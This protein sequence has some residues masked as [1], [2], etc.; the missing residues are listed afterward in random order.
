[1]GGKA[2]TSDDVEKL[3]EYC[4]KGLTTDQIAEKLGRTWSAVSGQVFNM[5]KAGYNLAIVKNTD[6]IAINIIK[7]VFERKTGLVAQDLFSELPE[8]YWLKY[9]WTETMR[10]PH[11]KYV[12]P[13][14]AKM[15]IQAIDTMGKLM[16]RNKISPLNEAELQIIL[17][18]LGVL[19]DSY[20]HRLSMAAKTLAKIQRVQTAL[21]AYVEPAA[22]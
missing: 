10:V 19:L 6:R 8:I 16:E 15:R 1:M 17:D 5:R 2:W 11:A 20:T 14:L 4:E 18:A 9:S 13:M 12:D 7:T 22:V 21:N 3:K